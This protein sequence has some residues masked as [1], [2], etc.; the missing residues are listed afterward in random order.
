MLLMKEYGTDAFRLYLYQ[1]NAML[2]NDLLF[3]ENGLKEANQQILLPL[4]SCTSFF[5]S[6]AEIDGF[7][8]DISK[9]PDSDNSLDKWVLARLYQ[10][11]KSISHSMDKYQV[12]EYVKPVADFIDDLSN[13][14]IRRSRR[15]F[16]AKGMDRDKINAYETLYYVLTNLYKIMA[17][18]TPILI[19]KLYKSLTGRKS[20]H[21]E[22]WPNIDEKFKNEKLLSDIKLVQKTIYLAR[23][24][25]TKNN[26]KNRQPLNELRIASSNAENI[27]SMLLI[28]ISKYSYVCA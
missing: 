7:N 8:G 1:S 17:P 20:V 22:Q 12:D 5:V 6:Y 14:Y 23:T 27:F 2:M 28:C 11:E 24:I 4:Y 15:R 10:I 19:E 16:W 25:R 18:I 9:V 13:W 21:L 26:V 3:D